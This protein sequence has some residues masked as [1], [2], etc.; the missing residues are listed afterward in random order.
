MAIRK[1][2]ARFFYRQSMTGEEFICNKKNLLPL[3]QYG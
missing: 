3:I 1:H 2:L